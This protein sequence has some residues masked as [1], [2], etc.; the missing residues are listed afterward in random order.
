MIF[1]GTAGWAIPRTSA[2]AFSHVEGSQLARYAQ[3]LP[4]VE[5]N[6]SFQRSHRPATYAR[7]AA[8]TPP[9][10]R[11]SVKLPRTITHDARLVDAEGALDRFLAEAGELGS[12]LG[13]LLVQLPPSLAFSHVVADAFFSALRRL[14]DGAAVVEARHAS[15]FGADA[16]AAL[17]EH[18]IGRAAADPAR[19]GGA[20]RPGGWLG[21]PGCRAVAYR[22]WHGSPLMYRSSY[23]AETLAGWSAEVRA[24]GDAVDCW[25]VFDNTMSGAATANALQLSRLLAAPAPPS[26]LPSR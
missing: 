1:I 25:C 11:F 15:W 9:A 6:S 3:L 7:W 14:H 22:R 17:V 12:R 23:P 16:E 26:P 24:S 4:C 19:V 10:F 5:I 18:R 2:D 13:P 21:E 8:Q 20:D